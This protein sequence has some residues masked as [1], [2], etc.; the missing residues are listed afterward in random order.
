MQKAIL[1]K[2]ENIPLLAAARTQLPL[3]GELLYHNSEPYCYLKIHDDFIYKL[4]P[5][6]QTDQISMPAYFHP[7]KFTGAHI[8]LVYPNEANAIKITQDLKLGK[9]ESTAS[10]EVTGFASMTVFNKT[11][12]ALTVTSPELEKIR[13]QYGLSKELNYKGFLV[14]FHITLGIQLV[15]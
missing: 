13:T 15:K 4:F 10:F 5:F 11:M 2:C 9:I 14:P 3:I 12:Y 6:I 8:S 7:D 1:S